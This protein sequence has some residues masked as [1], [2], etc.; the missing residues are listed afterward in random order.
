MKAALGIAAV[1][2]V[3]VA[4]LW[5]R[6]APAYAAA[7]V[8]QVGFH[9][10]LHGLT[11]AQRIEHGALML[12]LKLAIGQRRELDDGF[13]FEVDTHRLDLP[14]LAR[15]VELERGCCPFFHFSIDVGPDTGAT[16]LRLTGA[17][18]V[19]ELVRAELAEK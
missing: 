8:T 16:W 5:V 13:A 19:K 10:N 3:G 11:P 14:S 17:P 18:G 12:R 6:R 2:L 7:P 15:W 4:L 1:L 9:C